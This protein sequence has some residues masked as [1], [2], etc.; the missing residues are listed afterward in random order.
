LLVGPCHTIIPQSVLGQH[1]PNS[2]PQNLCASPLF[3]HTVHGDF[4][5]A[6]RTSGVAVVLLLVAFL[7][8]GVQIVQTNGDNVVSAVGRG[9]PDRLVLAHEGNGNL[10]SDATKGTRVSTDV[11]EVPCARVGKCGVYLSDVLRHCELV[12]ARWP[13]W[14]FEE[15]S[16]ARWRMGDG[17]RTSS[18]GDQNVVRSGA[19]EYGV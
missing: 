6:T 5:Q 19:E 17:M 16:G 2:S 1:T 7:S 14:C 12:K 3:H 8:G 15:G 10:R 13:G 11:N 18:T 4:L 9:V